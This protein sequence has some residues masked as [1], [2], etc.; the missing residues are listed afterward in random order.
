MK[1][2]RH[3]EPNYE[4]AAELAE[5]C[6]GIARAVQCEKLPSRNI[7]SLAEAAKAFAEA[8]ELLLSAN[9]SLPGG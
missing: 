7:K 9:H 2:D 1:T 3:T 4:A 6:R 8:R 5:T